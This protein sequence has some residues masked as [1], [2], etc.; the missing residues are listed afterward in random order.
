MLDFTAGYLMT[1]LIALAAAVRRR[2]VRVGT[3]IAAIQR[4][5]KTQVNQEAGIKRTAMLTGA[6]RRALES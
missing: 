3:I 1:L 6:G 2:M 4:H 5:T